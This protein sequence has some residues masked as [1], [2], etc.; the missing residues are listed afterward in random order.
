[1]PYFQEA[2]T[3]VEGLLETKKNAI[4]GKWKTFK[5]FVYTQSGPTGDYST[6]PW[7]RCQ[8]IAG[9]PPALNSLVA[10]EKANQYRQKTSPKSCKT[11]IKILANPGL[12]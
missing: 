3:S 11:E 5:V 12:A 6:L 1:M 7:M 2:K 9:L 8:S 10:K 4:K